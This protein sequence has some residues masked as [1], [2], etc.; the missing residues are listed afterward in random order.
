MTDVAV[1]GA[2][3]VGL[4]LLT[5]LRRLGVDAAGFERASG[6][7]RYPKSRLVSAGSMT[8]F[9]D[10]GLAG[11]VRAASLDPDWCQ[12][13]I[14]RRSLSEPE[15]ARVERPES[16]GDGPALCTQDALERI[17]VDALDRDYPGTVRWQRVVTG[18]EPDEAGVTLRL[19]DPRSPRDAEETRRARYVVCADGVRGLSAGLSGWGRRR[20]FMRQVSIRV[21][22]ALGTPPAFITYLVDRGLSA[23]LLVVDGR[24]DWIVASLARRDATARDY[25]PD[26]ARVLLAAVTGLPVTDPVVR[27]AVFTDVRMWELATRVSDTF[28]LDRVL[29]AGD[30]AHEILPTGAMGLNLGLADA[31][32]LAGP[33][34]ALVTEQAGPDVLD[35]YAAVRRAAALRTA[36]WS[37]DNLNAVAL[38]LG[39]A[40]RGEDEALAK[41]TA[42]LAPYLDPDWI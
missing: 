25:G 23:Q 17:L 6:P 40:A 15:L 16:T 20:P 34:A 5:G 42:T 3:P 14:V 2:G 18:L 32:A 12:R 39:A 29:R 21:T 9:G 26:R 28:R 11:A 41:A 7:T 4:T 1:I 37:R 30:A 13:L 27:D 24:D 35:D 36:Q 8:I 38:L 10:L 19:R 33:L 31:A 22:A